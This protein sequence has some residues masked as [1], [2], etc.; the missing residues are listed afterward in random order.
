MSDDSQ[1]DLK[2]AGTPP[3]DVRYLDPAARPPLG[4]LRTICFGYMS[5]LLSALTFFVGTPLMLLG[6]HGRGPHVFARLW[7][8]SML[9]CF[10]GG[11]KLEGPGRFDAKEPRLVVAN[12]SSYLDVCSIFGWYPGQARFVLKQELLRLPF[13]GWYAK[14]CGHFLLDRENPRE[15]KRV[16]DRAVARAKKYG[17]S[18]IVFPE[19]TR[20]SDGKLAPLKAGVFQLA[21]NAQMPIQPVAIFRTYSMMPRGCNYPRYAGEVVMRVG[22][23]ISVEGLR[24]GP[25]RRQ[26][27]EQV[28]QAFRDLGVE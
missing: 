3:I 18:P 5:A 23:P 15:G 11:L 9:G 20:T 27:A 16:V 8:R 24:G 1:T 10:G 2:V 13:I 26:L 19:G 12:H 6:A 21:I 4:W 14:L 28:E 7:G 25:G 17:L 22:E